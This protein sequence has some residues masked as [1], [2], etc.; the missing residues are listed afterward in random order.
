MNLEKWFIDVKSS[1]L[2][3]NCKLK[4]YYANPDIQLKLQNSDCLEPLVV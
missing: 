4:L 2:Y 1:I 3:S